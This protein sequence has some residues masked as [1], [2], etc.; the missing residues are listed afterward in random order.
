[1]LLVIELPELEIFNFLFNCPQQVHQQTIINIIK[2][3]LREQL[4]ERRAAGW[5]QVLL[6][7]QPPLR[8]FP[9]HTEDIVRLRSSITIDNCTLR[10]MKSK[11]P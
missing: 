1:M 8:R 6:S 4:I 3:L 9:S 11:L 7:D 2:E 5:Y 10:G